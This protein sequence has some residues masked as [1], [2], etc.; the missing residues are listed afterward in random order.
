MLSDEI[1]IPVPEH[2]RVY[3][4][5]FNE[6]LRLQD[7]FGRGDNN[8]MKNLNRSRDGIKGGAR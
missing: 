5:L 2:S 1:Y 8:V 7:Y 4:Q 6:Y 3:N